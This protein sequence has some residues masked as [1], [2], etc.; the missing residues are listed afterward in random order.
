MKIMKASKARMGEA[1][2]IKIWAK[3]TIFFF[4]VDLDLTKK[5]KSNKIILPDY[6]TFE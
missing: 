2:E 3:Q 1:L 5:G 6:L 4:Q